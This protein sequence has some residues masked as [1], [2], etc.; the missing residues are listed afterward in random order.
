MNRWILNRYVSTTPAAVAVLSLSAMIL[1]FGC[2]QKA[3]TPSGSGSPATTASNDSPT[4]NATSSPE[5]QSTQAA[6]EP[7]ADSQ[8]PA[9]SAP[10]PINSEMALELAKKLASAKT[11]D[12][13]NIAWGE[14]EVTKNEDG[15]FSIS[16]VFTADGVSHPFTCRVRI[17]DT[18]GKQQWQATDLKVDGG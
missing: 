3:P 4:S 17:V 7:T 9:T 15:S 10:A 12:P 13:Q 6:T 8:T 18:N 5:P 11:T 14:P 1:T 16:G 2:S